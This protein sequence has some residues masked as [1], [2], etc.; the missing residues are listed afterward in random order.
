MEGIDPDPDVEVA[1]DDEDA[2]A[3]ETAEDQSS[4]GDF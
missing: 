2:T 1:A 3:D 4:L